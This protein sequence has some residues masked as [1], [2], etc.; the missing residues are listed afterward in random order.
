MYDMTHVPV[1]RRLTMIRH[2]KPHNLSSCGGFDLPVFSDKRAQKRWDTVPLTNPCLFPQYLY[3]Y[4]DSYSSLTIVTTLVIIFNISMHIYI[5]KICIPSL[6][7]SL[8]IPSSVYPPGLYHACEVDKKTF[9]H[10]GAQLLSE[11]EAQQ[12][13]QQAMAWAVQNFYTPELDWKVETHVGG[14]LGNCGAWR[15]GVYR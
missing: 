12:R 11:A 7:A 14:W 8:L 6:S 2:K 9:R 3:L 15:C 5:Y 4:I 10:C 13:T 1:S